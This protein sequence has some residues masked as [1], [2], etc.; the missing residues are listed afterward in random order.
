MAV[1][2]GL[3]LL[4]VVAAFVLRGAS[5]AAFADK[6]STWRSDEEGARG[7]Y[8][9]AEEGGVRVLRHQ[10][11]LEVIRDGQALAL[12]AVAVEGRGLFGFGDSK[13]D[14]DGDD[15]G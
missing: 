1:V 14:S 2:F 9:L 3:I 13:G 4:A 5:R 8:L 11:S 6:L 10:Q 15:D 12:L 7:L